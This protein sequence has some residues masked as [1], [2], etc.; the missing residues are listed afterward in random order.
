MVEWQNYYHMSL[1][2][3]RV[4]ICRIIGDV[5]K[6]RIRILLL[7]LITKSTCNSF[8]VFNRVIPFI[9]RYVYVI[10]EI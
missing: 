10:R 1:L 4:G 2:L 3:V 7:H 6:D 5:I 9:K 8:A